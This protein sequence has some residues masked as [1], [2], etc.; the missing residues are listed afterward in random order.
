MILRYRYNAPAN[1]AVEPTESWSFLKVT[2]A[3]IFFRILYFHLFKLTYLTVMVM[4]IFFT[5]REVHMYHFVMYSHHLILHL[6]AG[7][8]TNSQ[9]A[10]SQFA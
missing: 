5:S 8:N 7:I 3:R 9:M 4:I 6:R 10:N 1:Q 2:L